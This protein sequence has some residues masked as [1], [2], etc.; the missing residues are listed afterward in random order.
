VEAAGN[1]NAGVTGGLEDCDARVA[2][3]GHDLRSRC[4][5]GSERRLIAGRVPPKASGNVLGCSAGGQ[6]A[7]TA[8]LVYVNDPLDT[9]LTH[10]STIY[11]LYATQQQNVVNFYLAGIALL[12]V[13]YAAVID[14]HHAPVAVA[15]CGLGVVAS[16]VAFLHDRR[17]RALMG[18]AEKALGVLQ[19]QLATQLATGINEAPDTACV[20]SL[21]IQRAADCHRG[22][23][24][25]EGLGVV[26]GVV[27]VVFVL[28][29]I[30]AAVA[31]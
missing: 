21:R 5:S 10:V 12:S 24:R 4:R 1:G 20:E 25:G 22:F 2:E 31:H 11:G 6:R 17:H 29:A 23:W 7:E 3:G 18:L 30:Y 16:V 15:V 19:A 27:A 28:G 8:I 26:Y 14:K 13:A 9:A